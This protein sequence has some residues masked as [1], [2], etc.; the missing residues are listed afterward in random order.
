MAEASSGAPSCRRITLQLHSSVI[1]GATHVTTAPFCSRLNPDE[2]SESP[3]EPVVH[4]HAKG[5]LDMKSRSCSLLTICRSGVIFP[6][7]NPRTTGSQQSVSGGVAAGLSGG[8]RQSVKRER[9]AF[10]NNQL[11]E[12]EKEFHFSPY[13]CRPRRMEMAAGLQLTDRQ[14]KIWFQNR[15]MRYKREHRYGKTTGLS[16]CSYN[17]SSSLNSCAD[18]LSVVGTSS[19]SSDSM[20]FASMSSLFGAFRDSGDCLHPA[21]LPRLNCTLP[22]VAPPS[23][24][25][26]DSHH[27]AGVSNWP[28]GPI[29]A[30]PSCAHQNLNDTSTFSYL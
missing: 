20:D 17:L 3:L 5:K 7:M 22:S 19:S 6:W 9:T 18:R 12:L 28:K 27:H 15:R 21:D 11:L 14:V 23:C 4:C 2:Q 10:T 13:L 26:A 30:I 8:G 16:Q 29:A 24:T 1:G 25:G